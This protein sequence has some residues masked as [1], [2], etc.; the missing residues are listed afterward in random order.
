MRYSVDESTMQAH[1]LI[2]DQNVD[3]APLLG[4]KRLRRYAEATPSDW[5]YNPSIERRVHGATAQ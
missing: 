2:N 4:T 5:Y 1:D 3:A